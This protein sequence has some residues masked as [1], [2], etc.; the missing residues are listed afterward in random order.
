V[1]VITAAAFLAIDPL[2]GRFV[3]ILA[4]VGLAIRVLAVDVGEEGVEVIS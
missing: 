4:D 1:I 2:T 3:K